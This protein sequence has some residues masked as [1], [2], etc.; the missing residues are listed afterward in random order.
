MTSPKKL[1]VSVEVS[2]HASTKAAKVLAYAR[3]FASSDVLVRAAASATYHKPCTH[4]L[5]VETIDEQIS[6][7]RS[8]N[9]YPTA[10]KRSRSLTLGYRAVLSTTKYF[11]ALGLVHAAWILTSP[12]HRLETTLNA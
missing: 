3:A 12:E 4:S 7:V 5:L 2:W 11:V 10:C 8:I 6:H 9:G 1:S